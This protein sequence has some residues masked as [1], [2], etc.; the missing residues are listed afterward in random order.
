M[1][2]DGALVL[3]A[4]LAAQRSEPIDE[5]FGE[6]REA[7]VIGEPNGTAG[8]K[9]MLEAVGSAPSSERISRVGVFARVAISLRRK[10]CE[11]GERTMDKRVP[12]ACKRACKTQQ[13]KHT[14]INSIVPTLHTL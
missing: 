10:L 4:E 12:F 13:Q 14:L 8:S 6:L 1:P 2:R 9:G 11:N 7:L 5:E 3:L